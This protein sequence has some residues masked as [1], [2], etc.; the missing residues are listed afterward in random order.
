MKKTIFIFLV[1]ISS[2]LLA[3]QKESSIPINIGLYGAYFTQPGIKVGTEIPLKKWSN[4]KEIT[5][6]VSPQIGGFVRL[7][8]HTSF[9]VNGDIGY[10]IK[11]NK[12]N[13]Y[14]APSIGLGY[15]L[16]SQILSQTV[17]LSN[18][19]IIDKDREV[20]NYFL[21]TVN[22]EFGREKSKIGWYSKLSYGRKVSSK[23]ED[24]GFFALEIGIK[25]T[26]KRK[27]KS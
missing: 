1:L 11:R 13:F 22:L 19:D 2:N 6:F 16:S 15:L 5:L 8:N 17:D 4:K 26:I 9:I 18:G 10:K 25:F 23:I 3:Q 21:P 24:S 14:I 12:R 27:H 7:R 20:R